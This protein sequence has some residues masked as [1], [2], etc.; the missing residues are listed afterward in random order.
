M[1]RLSVVNVCGGNSSRPE[2]KGIFINYQQ[3]AF[4]LIP[5]TKPITSL[6][7]NKL[8]YAIVYALS[9]IG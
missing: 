5:K 1:L 7:P 8:I 9:L 3:S 4:L 2:M 6:R